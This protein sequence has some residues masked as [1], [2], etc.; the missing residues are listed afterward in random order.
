MIDIKEEEEKEDPAVPLPPSHK[1]PLIKWALCWLFEGSVESI[2]SEMV[3]VILCSNTIFVKDSLQPR[4]KF[5]Y[6][7][8]VVM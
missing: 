2:E 1:L 6:L 4:R 7:L 8:S 5:L 3:V